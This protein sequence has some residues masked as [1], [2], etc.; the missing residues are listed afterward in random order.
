MS[1]R[2]EGWCPR[3]SLIKSAVDDG[4]ALTVTREGQA[5]AWGQKYVYLAWAA[6]GLLSASLH[7]YGDLSAYLNVGDIYLRQYSPGDVFS[8]TNGWTYNSGTTDL[9]SVLNGVIS[10]VEGEPFF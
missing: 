10:W 5:T 1:L 3:Q 2:M 9:V 6:S 4:T 7:E 8:I